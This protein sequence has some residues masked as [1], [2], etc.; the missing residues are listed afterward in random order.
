VFITNCQE[1]EKRKTGPKMSEAN[2]SPAAHAKVQGRPAWVEHS[3]ANF[4][5]RYSFS[6]CIHAETEI[7]LCKERGRPATPASAI[8]AYYFWIRGYSRRKSRVQFRLSLSVLT[9]CHSGHP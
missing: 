8:A 4:P 5:K 9:R 3:R 1:W 6:C 7:A 2:T